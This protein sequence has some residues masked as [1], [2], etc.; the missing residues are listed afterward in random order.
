MS[1]VASLS[2]DSARESALAVA[3]TEGIEANLG[4]WLGFVGHEDGEAVEL[5]ALKVVHE[6]WEA[7]YGA[8]GR[9]LASLVRLLSD[10]EQRFRCPGL[11]LIANRI[12]DAVATRAEPD[13]W[14]RLNKGE[15]TS[16]AEIVGRRVLFVDVDAVR[17][18]GTSATDAQVAI[19]AEVAGRVL[20]ELAGILG[21][22][23]ATGL[24][25]SGN[26][27]ALALALDNLSEGS[28]GPLIR[29]I[30][31]ALAAKYSGGGVEIDTSVVDAKRLVPAWGTMKRKGSPGVPERPHR[32]TAFVCAGR[33]RR[34]GLGE[35]EQVL[36]GL[37]RGLTPSQQADVDKAM[38]IKS[39]LPTKSEP[40]Q[41]SQSF[42]GSPFTRAN[43]VPVADVLGWLDLVDGERAVCPGCGE[44]D[45]GVAVVGNGLK[46]SHRRCAAKGYADGFR[47]VVDVVAERRGITPKEAVATLAERF[48]FEGIATPTSQV[49][50]VPAPSGH[51]TAAEPLCGLPTLQRLA[52]MG[53]DRIVSRAA[54]PVV[55]LWHGIVVAGT[56]VIVAGAPG[57]GKTTLMFL[58]LVAR[59]GRV[60]VSVLG[61]AVTP[62]PE[63]RRV[64]LIE[65]E[66]GDASTARKLVKSCEA[67]GVSHEALDRVIV[68]ARADVKLG[69]V[70]WA[71]TRQ[72]IA[73]GLVS[74]VFVDSLARFTSADAN[75]EQEQA[76][77]FD[78]VH[79]AIESS[80]EPKPTFWFIAHGR[81]GATGGI[82]DVSGSAQRAAQGDSVLFVRAERAPDGRVLSSRVTFPKLRE[83]PDEFPGE[84]RFR[85][86]RDDDDRW[87]ITDGA[88]QADETS[89]GPVTDRVVRALED[90]PKTKNQLRTEMG[91]NEQTFEAA[92]TELFRLRRV[93][94][95]SKTIR[96]RDYP[97]F[98]LRPRVDWA[99]PNEGDNE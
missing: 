11:Y 60:P 27:R 73:A 30:V 59:A 43:A 33:V 97:A 15:S 69:T 99:A 37:R 77:V 74:D 52:L 3:Q 76:A 39:P 68:L 78:E 8:H 72:L 90:G 44:S 86:H 5:Q 23:D 38:G 32:R 53:R 4:R 29:G 61:L 40:R 48:G 17:P 34:L 79:R 7:S 13:R 50:A 84:R 20:G 94:R 55:Y 98:A 21:D 22:E 81:K 12:H 93:R 87:T 28:A 88:D 58:V 54:E 70:A 6:R 47:T 75:A 42:E 18:K 10:A 51:P 62:A 19:T 31:N 80:A 35:L 65:A 63:P 89:K 9:N 57:E 64:V 66:H 41:A 25:H 71:E 67:L 91:V 36:A 26:G 85:L 83:E 56:V 82:D 46:C 92:V 96:G 24:G 45:Q 2:A 1:A 95:S 49:L 16:D 14:H